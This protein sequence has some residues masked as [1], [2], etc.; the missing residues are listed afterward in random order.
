LEHES[1]KLYEIIQNRRAIHRSLF[2]ATK[3]LFGGSSSKSS[4]QEKFME[5]VEVQLRR[6]GDLCFMLQLYETAAQYYSTAKRDLSNEQNWVEA[7][8]ASEFAAIEKV[9]NMKTINIQ[10]LSKI[11]NFLNC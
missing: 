9:L 8:S 2:S 3:K 1:K 11:L 4:V 6:F 5:P 10:F 7:T